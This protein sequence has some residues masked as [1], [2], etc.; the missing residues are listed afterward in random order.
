MQEINEYVYPTVK[1]VTSDKASKY[2]I[3]M[4]GLGW[5]GQSVYSVGYIWADSLDKVHETITLMMKGN[6]VDGYIYGSDVNDEEQ[7]KW[8]LNG[9]HPTD[10][11]SLAGTYIVKKEDLT[12]VAF[13][14]S[15][16]WFLPQ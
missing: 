2:E 14:Q 16:R 15:G 1:I 7:R 13:Y 4:L 9:I 10:T 3:S 6:N 11:E 12:T 5:N 8:L